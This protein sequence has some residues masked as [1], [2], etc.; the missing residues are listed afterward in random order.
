MIYLAT[1][2]AY[3]KC[4]FVSMYIHIQDVAL[5]ASIPTTYCLLVYQHWHC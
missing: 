3:I 2:V 1:H 5:H 4:M